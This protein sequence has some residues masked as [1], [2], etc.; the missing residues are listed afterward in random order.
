MLEKTFSAVLVIGFGSETDSVVWIGFSFMLLCFGLFTFSAPYIEDT[1]DSLDK[2]QRFSS[3]IFTLVGACLQ[4]QA[5]GKS[6]GKT[7]AAVI[8]FLNSAWTS[9]SMIAAVNPVRLYRSAMA[10]LEKT[11]TAM[12]FGNINEKMIK[13]KMSSVRVSLG[14]PNDKDG[15]KGHF[16]IDKDLKV[17]HVEGNAL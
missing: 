11:V 17:T 12:K 14:D 3:V 15:V 2:V 13:S 6:A 16:K 9:I 1:S 5:F 8:L 4:V 7:I 10:N